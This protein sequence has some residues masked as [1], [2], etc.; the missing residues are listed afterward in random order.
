M[1][2]S[3]ASCDR[4]AAER[5]SMTNRER[6]I[7]YPLLAFALA[8]GFKNVF[9]RNGIASFQHVECNSLI[10]KSPTGQ[11]QVRMGRIHNDNLEIL[12]RD[13]NPV[14]RL[15]SDRTGKA[16]AIKIENPTTPSKV[17]INGASD[18]GTIQIVSHSN[19]TDVNPLQPNLLIGFDQESKQVG[20]IAHDHAADSSKSVKEKSF[21]AQYLSYGLLFDYRGGSREEQTDGKATVKDSEQSKD[22]D[23]AEPTSTSDGE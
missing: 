23:Q 18:G 3:Y 12:N 15:G 22:G 17:V 21:V 1:N 11:H 8:M 6:W 9:Q 20:V 7:V 2:S 19:R 5:L 10:V 4:V 14:I 13:G 16:G